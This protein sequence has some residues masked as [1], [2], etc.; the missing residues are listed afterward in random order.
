MILD[1]YILRTIL[2]PT[3]LI[4]TILVCIFASFMAA[5]YWED[6]AN[7]LLSA[8]VVFK[9]ILL[10]VL[11]ALE[12][13]LPTT[14]YLSVVL[15][16]GN[17]HNKGEILA[18]SASGITMSR[19][20]RSVV[21]LAVLSGLLVGVFSLHIRPWAWT[22]FFMLKAQAQANFDLSRMQ[23]GIFYET[24]D[25]NRVIFASSVDGQRT[26][27]DNIFLLMKRSNSLRVVYANEAAQHRDANHLSPVV[28]LRQGRLYEFAEQSDKGLVLEFSGATLLLQQQSPLLPEFRVKAA[29]VE[30][31]V[32]AGTLEEIAELQWRFV[33]PLS[34]ILLAILAIPLSHSSKRQGRQ[35]RLPLAIL[36]FAISYNLGAVTKKMVAQ[37]ELA[38]F[39]GVFWSQIFVLA[40]LL[41]LIW[42][43]S[44][45]RFRRRS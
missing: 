14:L 32:D 26:S 7:G 20:S 8:G 19:I 38:V 13:L 11:I 36:I 6:A 17:L 29:P 10:R 21:L 31:L 23:D 24:G 15:A 27:A 1:R 22:Q 34:C 2:Q 43:A 41:V 37:G 35:A 39:P 45:F 5:R 40:C 18:M 16:L 12:V 33:T 9:L 44:R 4:C 25:G 42:R 3:I 28:S 30:A